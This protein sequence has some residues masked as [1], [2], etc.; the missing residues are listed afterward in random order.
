MTLFLFEI[1]SLFVILGASNNVMQIRATT[2]NNIDIKNNNIQDFSAS[3]P[4]I[5]FPKATDNIPK[6]LK[7][8]IYFR[9][10]LSFVMLY[11]S[12]VSVPDMR[13]SPNAKQTNP[14]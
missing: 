8:P 5:K 11:N 7:N 12:E 3:H 14:I 4:P 2:R 9:N 1:E 6:E 13:D 10:L